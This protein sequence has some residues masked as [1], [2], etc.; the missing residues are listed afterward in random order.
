MTNLTTYQTDQTLT[1]Y[2]RL[3]MSKQS[4][5]TRTAYSHDLAAF[6]DFIGAD[7][8]QLPDDDPFAW[9]ELDTAIIAAY[10][11]HLKTTVSAH[12]S[13]PYAT[14]TIARKITAVKELLTEAVYQGL[15]PA[16]NL[17]YIKERLTIPEVTSEHHAGISPDEQELLLAEA[18]RQK[19]LKGMRDYAIFRVWLETGI[20]RAELTG[21]KVRDLVV[22]EGTA[23]IVVRHGKGNKIRSIPIDNY[24]AHIINA[25]LSESGQDL[26]ADNPIFC[27]VRKVGRGAAATYQVVNPAKHL[28]TVALNQLVRWYVRR[29]GIESKVTPHSFRVALVTDSLDGGAPIQHVQKVTGHTSTRMITDVY[30]RNLYSMPVSQYRKRELPEFD[31]K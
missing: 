23:N 8:T 26:S 18:A 16:A 24:T 21:L 7:I 19:G 30:D 13:R 3:M 14:A 17:K 6:S 1:T 27:Q 25:W 11:E 2:Q 29:C 28:Q 5:L 31:Q 22:R 10:I 9:R 15:Y 4:N 20:R 12:T